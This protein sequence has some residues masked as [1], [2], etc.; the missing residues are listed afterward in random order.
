MTE[1]TTHSLRIRLRLQRLDSTPARRSCEWICGESALSSDYW[2]DRLAGLALWTPD[3]Q[4]T[5][6]RLRCVLYYDT[7]VA[8]NS[9]FCYNM[10]DYPAVGPDLLLHE[11][12]CR[13]AI[14]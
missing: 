1:T 3:G 11:A 8:V 7:L 12:C 10:Q 14:A 13:W 6:S 9:A 5:R 4:R 2:Q